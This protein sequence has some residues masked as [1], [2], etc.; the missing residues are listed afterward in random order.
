MKFNF[1][2]AKD[3]IK[4]T[5]ILGGAVSILSTGDKKIDNPAMDDQNNTLKDKVEYLEIKDYSGPGPQMIDFNEAKN[6]LEKKSSDQ[7]LIENINKLENSIQESSHKKSIVLPGS[8]SIISSLDLKNPD[9][10]YLEPLNE[11]Y[12]NDRVSALIFSENKNIKMFDRS[13][14]FQNAKKETEKISKEGYFT[15]EKENQINYKPEKYFIIEKSENND[16][17]YTYILKYVSPAK[18]KVEVISTI[19]ADKTND[20]LVN[21]NIFNNHIIPELVS[22]INSVINKK[23]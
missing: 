5:A 8:L 7:I 19:E 14:D 10:Q 21:E 3:V 11:R 15:T 16:T 9:I 17:S 13:S 12:V 23:I 20:E 6:N 22:A 4:K 2:K 1:E 18:N